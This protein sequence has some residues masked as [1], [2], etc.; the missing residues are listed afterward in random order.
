[1]I[2][3]RILVDVEATTPIKAAEMPT[4][5]PHPGEPHTI[6]ELHHAQLQIFRQR[7]EWVETRKSFEVPVRGQ[8]VHQVFFVV[9]SNPA[10][11]H[12]QPLI[13]ALIAP[14]ETTWNR[15]TGPL[16]QAGGPIRDHNIP[17][18][19]GLEESPN[20]RPL[21]W[22]KELKIQQNFTTVGNSQANGQTEV[23]NKIKLNGAKWS[24]VEELPDVLWAYQTTSKQQ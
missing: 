20:L 4:Y 8:I 6:Q 21:E 9:K 1:M 11:N 3:T 23:S 7:H 24:W 18:T 16:N 15:M 14:D 5:S 2:R 22:C 12:Y 10:S 17:R 19:R 13:I